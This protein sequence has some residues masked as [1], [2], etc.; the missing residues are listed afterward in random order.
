[1]TLFNS[2]T[3]AIEMGMMFAIPV[4]VLSAFFIGPGWGLTRDRGVHDSRL[5]Y[6][7][8]SC[9]TVAC[10]MAAAGL[11]VCNF[12]SGMILPFSNQ[13]GLFNEATWWVLRKL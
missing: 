8:M 6:W 7:W 13:V 5:A 10:Q 9:G 11:L 1:M 2:M 4:I 12:V 3:D